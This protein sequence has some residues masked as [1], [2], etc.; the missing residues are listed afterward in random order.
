MH[1]GGKFQ[2]LQTLEAQILMLGTVERH[3]ALV[4]KN[5]SHVTYLCP[6]VPGLPPM[7]SPPN[8]PASGL[9]MDAHYISALAAPEIPV[10]SG[11]SA[12]P[13]S[14]LHKFCNT[15]WSMLRDIATSQK[16]TFRFA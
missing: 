13:I 4:E 11:D 15:N 5:F 10:P 2:A 7:A 3:R 6:A 1:I 16:P 12:S 8:N 9:Q 14:G